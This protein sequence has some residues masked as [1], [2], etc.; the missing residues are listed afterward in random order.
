MSAFSTVVND[1]HCLAWF[2]M[3]V[4]AFGFEKLAGGLLGE[5]VVELDGDLIGDT[6]VVR[7][8]SGAPFVTELMMMFLGLWG[9]SMSKRFVV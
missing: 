1:V 3:L 2:G 8:D 5:E 9:V 6:G 7:L 4:V